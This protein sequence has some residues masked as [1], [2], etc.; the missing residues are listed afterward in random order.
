MDKI[1]ITQQQWAYADNKDDYSDRV[2]IW[3]SVAF[4]I[5]DS[6][7]FVVTDSGERYLTNFSIVPHSFKGDIENFDFESDDII[8]GIGNSY[9]KD[10][11]DPSDIGRTVNISFSGDRSAI[12]QYSYSDFLHDDATKIS[13]DLALLDGLK[14][15]IDELTNKLFA[16]GST[17][18]LQDGKPIIHG[19]AGDNTME[20][21]IANYDAIDFHMAD[22]RQLGQYVKNGIIYV[23]GDGNDS[24]DATQNNDILLGGNG[25]DTLNGNAGNDI[26][27]GGTGNDI[28]NPGT[29]LDR[30]NGGAGNDTYQIEPDFDNV[31]ISGDID[32]GTISLLNG[33]QFRRIS[34]KENQDGL[35]AAIDNNSEWIKGKEGWAVSVSGGT[36]TVS[37]TGADNTLHTIQIENFSIANNRFGIELLEKIKPETPAQDGMY[38]I[39]NGVIGQHDGINVYLPTSRSVQNSDDGLD[40][41][42]YRNTPLHFDQALYENALTFEGSNRNDLLTGKALPGSQLTQL[43]GRDGDDILYGETDPKTTEGNIDILV[44]GRG[45]DQ[46]YGGGGD[47]QL[48]ASEQFWADA[49]TVVDGTESIPADYRDFMGWDF[50]NGTLGDAV[51][52][53]D[54][55]I[56]NKNEKN[57]L[58]GGAGQDGL[59][60]ANYQDTLLG[61]AG[62]DFIL[63]GAGQ[64][65]IS[66]DDGDDF[67]YGDSH[68]FNTS[69]E[70]NTIHFGTV[71]FIAPD[72]EQNDNHRAYFYQ[73]NRDSAYFSDTQNYNDVI[74]GGNGTDLIFGEIG[75]DVISGGADDDRLFGDRPFNSGFFADFNNTNG[76]FQ[77]LS[78]SYNGDD[79]IDGGDGNDKI[80][81]GGG[82]DHLTGG[83]G[84]DIVYG[85]LALDAYEYIGGASVGEV[86]IKA[87]DVGWW[88]KDFILGAAGADTLVGEGND[89]VLDGGDGDDQLYGDWMPTQTEAFANTAA[90]TGND[91][92]F[93]GDGNDQLMGNSGDDIVE[94]GS[95][96]DILFGDSYNN[97]GLFTGT[98]ND[99][100]T[101]GTGNDLLYGGNGDDVL[102][103]GAGTDYLDGGNGNDTYIF[104]AGGGMDIVD[105]TRGQSTLFLASKPARTELKQD[106][107][108]IY[109]SEDGNNRIQMSLGSFRNIEK[110]YANN[111]LIN[112]EITAPTD[113]EAYISN[114]VDTIS[115]VI[116][117]TQGSDTFVFN[118]AYEGQF[119]LGGFQGND[120]IEISHGWLNNSYLDVDIVSEKVYKTENYWDGNHIETVKYF[121]TDYLLN[122]YNNPSGTLKIF[123]NSWDPSEE[124]RLDSGD[125][126]NLNIIGNDEHNIINGKS[127]SDQISGA[128]GNDSLYG[129]AGND[130]LAG[131]TGI[132]FLYGESGNDT[133]YVDSNDEAF[134]GEDDDT[135][136]AVANTGSGRVNG[137][138]GADTFN[139]IA[140][141]GSNFIIT[142]ERFDAGDI[143]Q[144]DVNREATLLYAGGIALLSPGESGTTSI[145][146]A[147]LYLQ[148]CPP[149]ELWHRMQNLSIRFADGQ[150]LDAAQIQAYSS[151]G[152]MFGDYI[153][154]DA[155][156][157]ILHGYGNNDTL[158]GLAGDDTLYGDEGNDILVGGTGA[159]IFHFGAGS[160]D[161]VIDERMD[162][163]WHDDA[164]IIQFDNSVPENGIT[165]THRNEDLII[166]IQNSGETLTLAGFLTDDG[167]NDRNITLSFSNGVTRDMAYIERELFRKDSGLALYGTA[168][169]ANNI[170]SGNSSPNYLYGD[171]DNDI[172]DGKNGN[173]WIDGGAG[174][175]SLTGG[176]G[177]DTFRFGS[178]SGYDV[179][180]DNAASVASDRI[181]LD[182]TTGISDLTI[183]VLADTNELKIGRH[184]ATGVVTDSVRVN[185]TLGH[186]WDINNHDVTIDSSPLLQLVNEQLESSLVTLTR[187]MLQDDYVVL[188][189]GDLLG[190]RLVNEEKSRWQI[191]AAQQLSGNL[192]LDTADADMDGNTNDQSF[193]FVENLWDTGINYIGFLPSENAGVANFQ[194]TLQRDDGLTLISNMTVNVQADS[195]TGTAGNDTIDGGQT[196]NPLSIDALAGDDLVRDGYGDDTLHGGDGND[197]LTHNWQGNG[198]DVYYGDAGDDTLDAGWGTDIM[199]GGSGH[200]LYIENNL[201]SGDH[202]LI[203]N[204]TAAAGDVDTLQIGQQDYGMWDYRSLWFTADGNDLLVNQL[205]A[206]ESGEIRIKDWFDATNPEARLDIIRVQQDNGNVY[207][208]QV[209][210][211]FD[212]LVQ[213]M[214]GFAPPASIGTID[215]SLADEYQAAWSL[216][217]PM[218]A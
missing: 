88:G 52:S 96:D 206:M 200:D 138:A 199:V 103:G 120:A 151:T 215:A 125:I 176:F 57:Y 165:L 94:G 216:V 137:G 205:D 107:A 24:I 97:G 214:A 13:P 42:Q 129:A 31:I 2:Y 133:L 181:R 114:G 213:A 9:L 22:H 77:H 73:D 110:I 74:D 194:F 23:A 64:D 179:I 123:N 159:D 15:G 190:A 38:N 36:A 121:V 192:G 218:A 186:F 8:A 128:G 39:G 7:R 189:A 11:I 49:K 163:G 191:T 58:D 210:V 161:D 87:S 102:N 75:N 98:G 217:A 116:T 201:W 132:D 14:N 46:L 188:S 67:I 139:V 79:A 59:Y 37:I 19:S 162:K 175:D 100:L 30:L 63:A 127:G 35:F 126:V 45:N 10:I 143:I 166:G 160:G 131:G 180:N 4:K 130:I 136:Y 193:L 78:S 85:D 71:D 204:S 149:E 28:L 99:V 171:A 118:D 60:G 168:T 18:F 56:E 185:K 84:N 65:R 68:V 47:D 53:G 40:I 95:G 148:D 16:A 43:D 105:D 195:L 203:D 17:R 62:N 112:L 135:F 50:T 212:A 33:V 197:I 178:G 21:D 111:E 173:D 113:N 142:D 109:L 54:V 157:N 154:G 183:E 187:N 202:T 208:T 117:G 26:L 61:G 55:S 172:I 44:G 155:S 32:G 211:Y 207:E 169:A 12:A 69:V 124:I 51:A 27:E 29:G 184:D 158:Y 122:N 81:G 20:G 164:D 153:I 167:K 5:S 170:I 134:G 25:T 92:L 150:T 115:S 76:I 209:D 119:T 106:N 93:G 6:T 66:G 196:D 80:I 86:A 83:V 91:K 48:Y 152:S 90:Q 156:N 72:A 3:N 198:D 41:E 147:A 146:V 89:D 140:A 144:L 1:Y 141:A 145:A 104:D 34:G 174:N 82:A 177:I 108:I 101:G 182:F 70:G